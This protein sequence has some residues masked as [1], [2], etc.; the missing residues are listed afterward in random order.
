MATR[1]SK[2]ADADPQRPSGSGLTWPE[3]ALYV[4]VAVASLLIAITVLG[5]WTTSWR[6]PLTYHMDAMGV[7]STVKGMVENG[8][9]NR[10]ALLGAPGRQ[11]TTGYPITDALP[12]LIIKLLTLLSHDQGLVV[13]LFYLLTYPLVALSALAVFRVFRVGRA[14]AAAVALLYAFLPYH[15][16]RG[17]LHLLLAAYFMVPPAMM[18]ALWMW[19]KQPPAYAPQGDR[20]MPALARPRS[21]ISMGVCFLVGLGGV[22]YA[23]FAAFFIAGSAV[24]ATLVDREWRRLVGAAALMAAIVLGVLIATAPYTLAAD[25]SAAPSVAERS[26]VEASLYGLKLTEMLLPTPGHRIPALAALTAGYRTGLAS[27]AWQLDTESEMSALGAF[28][29]LGLLFL[30]VWL[31]FAAIRGP[32]VRLPLAVRYTELSA[33]S[34]WGILLGTTGGFGALI[35]LALS[36]QIRAYNRISVFIAFL[37]LF[38]VASLLDTLFKRFHR[39]QAWTWLIA[40]AI[41]GV[42]VF[43]QT[44]PALVQPFAQSLGRADVVA[45]YTADIQFVSAVEAAVPAGSAVF[46]LPYVPYPEAGTTVGLPDYEHFGGYLHSAKLRWSYGAVKGTTDATWAQQTASLA[47]DLMVTGLKGA[48]FAGVWLDIRGYD[49]AAGEALRTALTEQLGQPVAVDAYRTRLFWTLAR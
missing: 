5:L 41:V 32:S 29:S 4:G 33:L 37:A 43:D 46:Q 11:S 6:I 21:V 9:T 47:P 24:I 8:W 12:L 44:T 20:W 35:A 25:R 14:S 42:G 16:M 36:A 40:V 10:N 23:F 26:P 39:I 7:Q 22:Y 48:G 38:A 1:R 31:P 30:L 27:V 2:K 15:L 18:V 45:K 34:V 17:E 3:V 49:Q 19:S 28:G 13:N